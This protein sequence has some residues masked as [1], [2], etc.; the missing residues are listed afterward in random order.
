VVFAFK[1]VR[2]Y[3]SGSHVI[4]FTDH[5]TVKHVLSKKDAKSRLVRWMLLLQEFDYE[6]GDRK[7]SKNAITNHL[8]TIM[9]TK[10]TKASISECFPDEQLF[11]IQS[12]PW[13]AKGLT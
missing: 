4:I 2:S 1:K 12:S 13:Y 8:S 7:C 9:C 3:L 6:I 10:S 11:V 5:A